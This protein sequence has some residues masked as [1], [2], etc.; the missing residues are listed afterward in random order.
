MSRGTPW[1]A[2]LLLA[3]AA[4]SDEGGL[5]TP[6]DAAPPD[7]APAP[8]AS[9]FADAGAPD[10][11]IDQPDAGGQGNPDW[12]LR[13]IVDIGQFRI[14]MEIRGSVTSTSNPVL[15]LG[16]DLGF[17]SEHLIEPTAFLLG[18][19]T[20][21]DA[22]RALIYTDLMAQGRSPISGEEE[23][24]VSVQ[25]QLRSLQNVVTYLRNEYF[26]ATTQFDVLGQGWGAVIA[27]LF[28]GQNPGVFDKVV[29]VAPYPIDVELRA[30]WIRAYSTHPAHDT[31]ALT[32][33]RIS[34]RC[35]RD[36]DQCAIDSF[37]IYAR[38]W[39]CRENVEAFL[40]LGIRGANGRGQFLLDLELRNSSYDYGAALGQVTADTTII[41]GACDLIPEA[42]F[43]AYEAGIPGARRVRIDDSGFFPM[44]ES[45][46]AFQAAVL[47]ALGNVSVP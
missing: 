19:G 26:D 21:E 2:S 8:D 35:F 20:G 22:A 40:E 28:D 36:V 45:P 16:F 6:T 33:L 25:N 14:F 30:D 13:D 10:V 32:D 39:V 18:S 11:V 4:C 15:M 41:T 29:M 23:S 12:V 31:R 1:V 34:P 38:P 17:G 44:V 7:A 43:E 46:A 5:S 47:E 42:N 24:Q 9:T 37:Y 27:T 3:A